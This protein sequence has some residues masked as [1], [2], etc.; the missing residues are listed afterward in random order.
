MTVSRLISLACLGFAIMCNAALAQT[1]RVV[2]VIVSVES[3]QFKDGLG[4]ARRKQIESEVAAVIV[5]ELAKPFPIVDWR[6]SPVNDVPVATLTAVVIE[7]QLGDPDT[8]D[9]EIKLVW[10]AKAGSTE[11]DL[12]REIERTLYKAS[13][14]DRPIDDLG[15]KFRK[16]L[17]EAAIAWVNSETNQDHLKARFLKHV[18]IANMVMP[19]STS[20]FVVVPLSWRDVKLRQDSVLRVEYEEGTPGAQQ[21]MQFTLTGM[22]PRLADPMLGKTQTLLGK[23][24]RGG[25]DVPQPE[26]W[27]KCIAPLN[28]DPPK[29][30]KVFA[31]AYNYEAHPDVQDGVIVSE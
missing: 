12:P 2:Q 16:A 21:Q 29:R 7:L 22:A 31:D 27:N 9:P 10:R 24:L 15:G 25:G 14:I 11:L 23:C 5:S 19:T 3:Q 18:L 20:D 17:G 30:V 4:T 8:S 13:V 6:A 26:S 1:P 28:T